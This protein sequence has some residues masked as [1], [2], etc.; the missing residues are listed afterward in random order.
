MLLKAKSD[1]SNIFK[2]L[3]F[4]PSVLK[5]GKLSLDFI[6]LSAALY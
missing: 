4:A 6:Y 1:F 5:S 2:I 3:K